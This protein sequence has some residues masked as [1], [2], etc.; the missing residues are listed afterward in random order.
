MEIV[1]G[2]NDKLPQA[3]DPAAE[4]MKTLESIKDVFII[5]VVKENGDKGYVGRQDGKV[6]I[7]SSIMP[8]VIKFSNYPSAK[9]FSNGINGVKKNILGKNRIKSIIEKQ[10]NQ[11][12]CAP[13]EP[14]P[15]EKADC[16]IYHILVKQKTDNALVGYLSLSK[17]GDEYNVLPNTDGASFWDNVKSADLFIDLFTK[18]FLGEHPNLKLEKAKY[19]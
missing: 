5:E 16:D 10:S 17:T 18:S 6:V 19:N 4:F 15:I 12:S 11:A 8:L 1:K 14:I 3:T 9:E 13:D 7:I 2:G